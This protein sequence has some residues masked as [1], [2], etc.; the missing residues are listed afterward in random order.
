MFNSY[1]M[2]LYSVGKRLMFRFSSKF[3]SLSPASAR[4]CPLHNCVQ[5]RMDGMVHKNFTKTSFR[6]NQTGEKAYVPIL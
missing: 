6:T 3:T 1:E 2:E 4:M 5:K